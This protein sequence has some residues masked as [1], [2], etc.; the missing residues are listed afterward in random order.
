MRFLFYSHDGVGFGHV[1]RHLAIASA[2][3]E[4]C[5]GAKVLV[6]TS[7]DEVSQLGLPPN[8]DTLKLPALRKVANN[9]YCS[10]R[11]GLPSAEIYALRSALL[12]AAVESFR[13][14]AVLVDKHPFGAGGEFRAALEA[15]KFLGAHAVLGLRD[16]LDSRAAVLKEWTDGHLHDCIADY[17]D[18]VLVYGSRSVFD[19]IAEYE[20]PPVLANRTRYCGYVVNKPGR[21]RGGEM[22]PA[23]LRPD[24]DIHPCVLA[25][26]GGGEDGF[27]V[28]E[29]FIRASEGAPWKAIAVAGP[30]LSPGEFD[31]LEQLA[32][33]GGVAL[34][35]FI[36]RLP[37]LFWKLDGL[38]CMGGY[39]TLVE[40]ASQDLATVCVPRN[41]P[42]S[43]QLLRAQ[44]FER[45]G[46]L[47]CIPREEL[48]VE[49]LR[50]EVTAA[51]ET[52][53]E[54]K[55]NRCKSVLD[56]G[57]AHHAAD[58][59]LDLAGSAIARKQAG[60]GSP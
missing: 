17:Y 7:L 33:Q 45:L 36:P 6:A 8:I 38:V 25:T 11:L 47:R 26:A 3:V 51:L 1:R 52:H 57:G 5:P 46:L 16:I 41:A 28:S 35:S 13:P 50:Y 27:T 49:K 23:F 12:Q 9:E 34:H 20:F 48:T 60:S 19:P 56:F 2:L 43:E 10:R 4:T 42:R 15:A 30:M 55:I 54:K 24:S 40:A 22:V 29:T 59:L 44:V 31:T 39:N 18:L 14:A 21:A 53:R 37:D 58:Y 32:T